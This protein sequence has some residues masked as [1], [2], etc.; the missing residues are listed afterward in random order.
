MKIF[1]LFET[2]VDITS[3]LKGRKEASEQ[4]ARDK[5]S[6]ERQ[7]RQKARQKGKKPADEIGARRRANMS[8]ED[9]FRDVARQFRD[10]D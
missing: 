3:K 9:K 4:E 8:M 5:R 2:V 10:K 1:E 6:V 7:A